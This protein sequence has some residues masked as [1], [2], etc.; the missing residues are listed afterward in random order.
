[1]GA[2]Q[3]MQA[4]YGCGFH[5]LVES[6][7]QRTLCLFQGHGPPCTLSL[8]PLHTPHTLY[9]IHFLSK[10]SIIFMQKTLT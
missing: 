10:A 2:T 4:L 6:V 8:S 5:H 1:M 7:S 9:H 3:S